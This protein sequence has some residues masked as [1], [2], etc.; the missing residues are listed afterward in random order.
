MSDWID[1]SVADQEAALNRSLDAARTKPSVRPQLTV[2]GVIVCLFCMEAIPLA[3]LK[4]IPNATHCTEC[5][6]SLEEQ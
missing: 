6:A 1:K 4:A 3:R 2:N 5:Q